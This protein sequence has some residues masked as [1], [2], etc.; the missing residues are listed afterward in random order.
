MPTPNEYISKCSKAT[1]KYNGNRGKTT[2]L[3]GKN[4][5]EN[6]WK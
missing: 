6:E 1:T 3:T 5:V 4:T 2:K